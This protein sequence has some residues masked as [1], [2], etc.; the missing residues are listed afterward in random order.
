MSVTH[1]V[2]A[3]K[4]C[5]SDDLTNCLNHSTFNWP[6]FSHCVVSDP[7]WASVNRGIL[8]CD[9]CCSVH[10]SLGRHISM[11]KSLRRGAWCPTQLAMVHTLS[12]NGANT[13]WE[14]TLLDSS[15]SKGSGGANGGA[16]RRKPGP[17]DL[18]HPTKADFIRAKH[19]NL[20]FLHRPGKDSGPLVEDDLHK[21]LHSS[22][23]TANVETSLRLLTQGADPNYFHPVS[24]A[25]IAGLGCPLS[26][27]WNDKDAWC[28]ASGF[29]AKLSPT[30]GLNSQHSGMVA[31]AFSSRSRC[32]LCVKDQATLLATEEFDKI[33]NNPQKHVLCV[34]GYYL[35]ESH[36]DVRGI[37]TKQAIECHL[38]TVVLSE[39]AWNDYQW[40]FDT[41]QLTFLRI[42]QTTHCAGLW[43]EKGN[44]PL[45]IA[46]KSG[47]FSQAELLVVYGADPAA[48]DSA[49][50]S[51]ADLARECG[52]TDLADRLVECQYELSDRL[53]FYLCGRKPGRALNLRQHQTTLTRFR[54]GHLKPLKIENNNKIYPTCP[55]CSLAPAAPEHILACI[56]CTKQDLWE[57]LL[58]IIK[59]LEEHELTGFVTGVHYIIP[60]MADSLDLSELAIE[61]RQR[62]RAV[63]GLLQL[64]GLPCWTRAVVE[65]PCLNTTP[66]ITDNLSNF[67]MLSNKHFEEL[68]MDLYDEVDRREIDAIWLSTQNQSA[69]VADRQT[70]PFLPVNR[71]FC[72]TRNQGRQKL[73]RF[74]AREFATLIIDV[75]TEVKRR[76]S[77]QSLRPRPQHR[78]SHRVTQ[79]DDDEPLYDS[80]ASDEDEADS[81]SKKRTDSVS[82]AD[83]VR[84]KEKLESQISLLLQ[85]NMGLKQEMALLHDMVQKL[86]TENTGLKVAAAN[87]PA[88]VVPSLPNGHSPTRPQSMF[89]PR[90]RAPPCYLGMT[91]AWYI[92][93]RIT[94][95]DQIIMG[96]TQSSH[97]SRTSGEYDNTPAP[98]PGFG[99]CP[100]T[101]VTSGFPVVVSILELCDISGVSLGKFS[102]SNVVCCGRSCQQSRSGS[103]SPLAEHLPSQQDVIRKTEQI[104]KKIQD[105]L[106]SAQEGNHT[107]FVCYK[108]SNLGYCWD[109]CFIPC[110]EKIY[111]AVLE[112]SS[113]FPQDTLALQ[114]GVLYREVVVLCLNCAGLQS[115]YW[116]ALVDESVQVALRQ[117]TGSA[118]RLQSEC[119]SLLCRQLNL[120]ADPQFI[121]QQVIQCAYDIAKA[122]K[123][124]VTLF[125]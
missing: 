109:S 107:R 69:L 31:I 11:V 38:R 45:H 92:Q 4:T 55:K 110:S 83:F 113:I 68:A 118:F 59:Q 66:S 23:R 73:A 84:V 36:V 48:P 10:R 67:P 78:P 103:L 34:A 25:C 16:I 15:H 77:P 5:C 61:A 29:L 37:A 14:H 87:T 79:S 51:S 18:L 44:T 49:G 3:K 105:L 85:D 115:E 19:Q 76:S 75:L 1:H 46:A 93:V 7:S 108:L 53:T 28:C 56:R 17:K 35:V 8:I 52:N 91:V 22:V 125:Q 21:Q 9:E 70:V 104:T 106:I 88:P 123:Q 112:M 111:L 114:L 39:G 81:R 98:G 72:T 100:G 41:K 27:S 120:S 90:A 121:T 12:N 95:D 40:E 63:S 65:I 117:L 119:K 24:W 54:T 47:Q 101:P 33:E 60:E 122:A 116:Q 32:V 13:I 97:S 2:K 50:R 58:L 71:D 57:R 20:S 96:Q 94:G 42:V 26:V 43:Q 64:G 99:S 102:S 86:K 74:N 82:V 89:E 124:L 62:L 30:V 6:P 80:V